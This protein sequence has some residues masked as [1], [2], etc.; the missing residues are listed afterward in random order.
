MIELASLT[1]LIRAESPEE[2]NIVRS[3][4]L[5][6]LRCWWLCLLGCHR[7]AALGLSGVLLL[8]LASRV[9]SHQLVLQVLLMLLV[10]LAIILRWL[11]L[12]RPVDRCL[13]TLTVGDT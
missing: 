5:A 2:T 6:E 12:L 9:E 4:R 10:L 13:P 8:L 7:L 11:H 3:L 1:K